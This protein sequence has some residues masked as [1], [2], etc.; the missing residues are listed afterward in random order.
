MRVSPTRCVAPTALF[1]S[2]WDN[3]PRCMPKRTPSAEGAIK[4]PSLVIPRAFAVDQIDARKQSSESETQEHMDDSEDFAQRG[5]HY[6]REQV[7]AVLDQ[8]E[9]YV[10]ER[11]TQ[12][13]LYAF[14]A[15][16]IVN[17][18]PIGRTIAVLLRLV[19]F[20]LK[21]AILIYGATKLYQALEE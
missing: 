7:D 6:A 4:N 20:A 15:G 11:P 17:R 12:S 8:T 1:N 3:A 16:L 9:H 21:P 5:L 18:L 19:L 2:A 13:L 10:R 14:L